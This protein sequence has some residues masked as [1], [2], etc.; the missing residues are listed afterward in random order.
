MIYILAGDIRTGKTSALEEWIG[1][2]D[3]V[4]GILCPDDEDSELRYLYNIETAE[5][6]PLQVEEA[7]ESTVRVGRFNFLE[8]S[9]KLAFTLFPFL[10]MITV[11]RFPEKHP[12]DVISMEKL[13]PS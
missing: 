7:A 3:S 2:W 11:C 1:T 9:F 10:E 12:T 8:D 6:F 4:K 13:S 5:R